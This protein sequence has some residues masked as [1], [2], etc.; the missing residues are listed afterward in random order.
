MFRGVKFSCHFTLSEVQE[1]WFAL[2]YEPII[3][4]MAIQVLLRLFKV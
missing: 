4:K 3:S 1:R 2:M